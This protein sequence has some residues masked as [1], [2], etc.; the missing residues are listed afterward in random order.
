MVRRAEAQRVHVG[1][2]PCAH[3]EDVAHDA[4]DAGRR[5][6]ER[7]DV[8]WVVVAFHLEDDGIAISEIDDARVLAGAL[9]HFRAARRQGFQPHARGFIRAVLAPHHRKDAKL[10]DQRLA[11]ENFEQSLVFVRLEAVLGNDLR[12]DLSRSRI[13]HKDL[14][15]RSDCVRLYGLGNG[16]SPS[17]SGRPNGQTSR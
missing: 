16:L 15:G 10:A 5:A 2:G 17:R 3:R 11:A 1:D 7:L 14:V 13:G 4:A 9:D 12:G 8:G 6:L